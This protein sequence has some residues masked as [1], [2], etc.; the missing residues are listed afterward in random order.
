V[1]HGLFFPFQQLFR[2]F[3][4]IEPLQVVSFPQPTLPRSAI[5]VDDA[6]T[7]VLHVVATT[8]TVFGGVEVCF[9]VTK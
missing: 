9:G 2:T 6:T 8:E 4:F 7:A 3:W 5:K 1:T